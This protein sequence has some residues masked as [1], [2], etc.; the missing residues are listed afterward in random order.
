MWVLPASVKQF[1]EDAPAKN[2][3]VWETYSCCERIANLL[4]WISFVPLMERAKV[5]PPKVVLFLEDSLQWILRHLE[6]Y[7]SKTGNHILN[8][9]R[10]LIMA[11]TVLNNQKAVETGKLIFTRLLPVLIQPDGFLR[12]RS[13]HYQLIILTWLLDAKYFLQV[14]SFTENETLNKTIIRMQTAARMLCDEAGYVQALIG[15]ISPDLSPDKTTQR[16]Q[17]CYSESWPG[18]FQSVTAGRD[19]WW[20]IQNSSDKILL[21]CPVGIYPRAHS[22]HGHNDIPAF[23]WLH[24]STPVFIDSGRSRY[25]K[26]PVSSRQKSSRGHSLP[27]VNGFSP[28]CES[29]V[30]NGNW[31]P[32]PY[33]SAEIKV[34]TGSNDITISHDGFMRAT[35]VTNH[36]R[37]IIL[38]P[39]EIEVSDQFDGKGTAQ[40]DLFWQLQPGFEHFDREKFL[41]TMADMSL[42]IDLCQMTAHPDIK[43]FGTTAPRNWC[44][45]EYGYETPNPLLTMRWHVTLPFTATIIFRVQP[46]AG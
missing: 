21:N 14:S 7:G 16:L 43:F 33:A 28:L 23:T 44:S 41:V 13:S 12:E 3:V 27:F 37:N 35:P 45:N 18:T 30:I 15:D 4:T 42:A 38:R 9:A 32:T 22:S 39:G 36:Q 8:N 1:I 11:G 17:F 5:M 26:D 6:Y 20:V 46:C 24:N 25:T 29:F 10:S 40:I 19:D 34:A 2:D 31:W